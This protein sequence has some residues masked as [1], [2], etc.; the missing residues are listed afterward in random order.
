MGIEYDLISDTTKEGYEL[1]KGPWGGDDFEQLLKS[2]SLKDIAAFLVEH[3]YP[4]D[5]SDVIAREVVEFAA[6]HPDWR[7]IDDCSC[8][9]WVATDEL[10]AEAIADLELGEDID[11]PDFP[12]YRKV[13]S[14]YRGC[15]TMCP[16]P[17][18]DS[19]YYHVCNLP[20][21]HGGDHNFECEKK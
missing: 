10:R 13:G 20:E 16:K 1:G 4:P 15:A 9:I 18:L 12:I 19:H 5:Y 3:K 21:K 6:A 7:I 14:R 2:A 11:D 8:E 17:H